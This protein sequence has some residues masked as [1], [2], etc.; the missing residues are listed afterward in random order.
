MKAMKL[1]IQRPLLSQY[2]NSKLDIR[3]FEIM[4]CQNCNIEVNNEQYCPSCGALCSEG[5]M[6]A[7]A[8]TLAPGDFVLGKYVIEEVLYKGAVNQYLAGFGDQKVL[9]KERA[10]VATKENERE[11]PGAAEIERQIASAPEANASLKVE[12][13]LLNSLKSRAFQRVYG[14]AKENGKEYLVLEYP[15][16][17]RLSDILA[18]K[19]VDEEASI[20]IAIELC[21]ATDKLHK[22]GYTHL[23]IEPNNIFIRD[24]EVK[25]LMSGRSRKLGVSGGDYLTTDGYSAPELYQDKEVSLDERADIYSIG[26]VLYRLLTN[27]ILSLGSIPSEILSNVH[28]AEMARILINCLAVNPESRYKSVDELRQKLLDFQSQSRMNLQANTAIISDVGMARQ[29][30]EDCGLAFDLKVWKESR[31]E[32]YGLYVVADG[33]GGEQAG[34]VASKKA[35]DE[36]SRIIWDSLNTA[37]DVDCN[38]IVRT[39]IEKANKKIYLLAG[40]NPELSSMGTTVTLG[41]RQGRELYIGH[42][43][44]SRAYLIRD[45]RILQLTEDHSLVSG[46]IKAGIITSEEAK[47]HPERGKIFRCLGSA[48][49]V[50]IDTLKEKS[51]ELLNG[52]SLIFCTDGLVN[53]VG[54]DELLA[55]VSKANSTYDACSRLVTLANERGGEDNVT[56][57]VV[58]V[59]IDI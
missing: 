54:D 46:L 32:S 45:D 33:M 20:G 29:N 27:E 56:I 28:R 36:I 18:S 25:L 37:S 5:D 47:T 38:H 1:I 9:V 51:L 10:T 44:D 52:D 43:G 7:S 57:V 55:E 58:K 6:Q 41:L 23:D 53:H 48:P 26:A 35:I 21:Q 40:D 30:N 39:A 15:V 13:E 12:F 17:K 22:L 14:Y 50:L 34:E 59:S 3:K 42:V 19:G 24:N 2:L 16:G 31:I 8:D 11:K 4:K 49:K